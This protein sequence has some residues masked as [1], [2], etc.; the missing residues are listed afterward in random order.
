[1][2][3]IGTSCRFGRALRS[4]CNDY[5]GSNR[6]RSIFYRY[7]KNNVYGISSR[8]S[9]FRQ[10]IFN[11]PHVNYLIQQNVKINGRCIYLYISSLNVGCTYIRYTF[12]K[13]AKQNFGYGEE[14]F[15]YVLHRISCQFGR[16]PRSTCNDYIGSNRARSIFYRYKCK[17]GGSTC[18][19]LRN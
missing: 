13:C 16:A 4:T 15:K 2:D 14:T 3:Y 1:V 7:K 6:A 9:R 12:L 17:Y 5:I 10:D 8:I 18:Q 19:L 11:D